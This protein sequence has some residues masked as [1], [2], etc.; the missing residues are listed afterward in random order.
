MKEQ[1][2]AVPGRQFVQGALE[3]LESLVCFGSGGWIVGGS[4]LE[5]GEKFRDID[6]PRSARFTQRVLVYDVACDSEQIGL[7]AANDVVLLDPHQA[8]KYFLG[9]I[10]NVGGV[11]SA[12]GQKATQAL[13]VLSS[14]RGDKGSLGFCDQL[15]AFERDVSLAVVERFGPGSGYG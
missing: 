11:S 8:Q 12:T 1:R 6:W 10:G 9:E 3:I 15:A 7:G 5:I 4:E 2:G 13:A 14:E